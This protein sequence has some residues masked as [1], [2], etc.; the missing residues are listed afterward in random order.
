M[1]LSVEG[2]ARQRAA[3]PVTPSAAPTAGVQLA[4][5]ENLVDTPISVDGGAWL[6]RPQKKQMADAADES[7][8]VNA[9]IVADE[10]FW[11]KR[12]HK[13]RMTDAEG[14]SNL[15]DSPNTAD[16]GGAVDKN[17]RS[18]RNLVDALFVDD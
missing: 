14:V 5:L 12:F 3:S 7:Y 8:L 9:R 16:E 15:V 11:S 1:S 2:D 10:V 6:N 4:M 17:A 13:K 18:K